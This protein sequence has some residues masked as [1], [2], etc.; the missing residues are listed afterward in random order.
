MTLLQWAD[1][2]HS[3]EMIDRFTAYLQ[4]GSYQVVPAPGASAPPPMSA[5]SV[6]P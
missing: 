4:P 1:R 3:R 6:E 2:L 5:E